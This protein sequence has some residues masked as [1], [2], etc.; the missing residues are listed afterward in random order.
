[1]DCPSRSTLF[2][3]D[4]VD[5][6]RRRRRG[7][8]RSVVAGAL[9][10]LPAVP[11]GVSLAQTPA[12]AGPARV[13]ILWAGTSS[14]TQLSRIPRGLSA[15]RVGRGSEPSL[16]RNA[17]RRSRNDVLP[18]LAHELVRSGVNVIVA[19][20]SATTRAAEGADD[21]DPDR[22]DRRRRSGP[23]WPRREPG[24]A[25]RQPDRPLVPGQRRDRQAAS[26]APRGSASHLTRGR[27]RE[28]D[29]PG[30][31][32]VRRG[33][34]AARPRRWASRSSL[35]RSR[36]PPISTPSFARRRP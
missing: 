10:I 24:A 6:A 16:S 5:I 11:L 1:M 33:R 12:R 35:P 29:Q 22:D 25:R 36:F 27:V 9:L 19:T 13:G 34:R 14:S 20:N 18:A 23:L 7:I 2:G 32:A 17:P 30:R 26:A 8:R 28:P 31:R 3:R 21:H 4:W 15:P